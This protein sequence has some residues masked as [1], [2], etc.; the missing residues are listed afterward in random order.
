[1]IFHIK[2]EQVCKII[3]D[4]MLAYVQ[5]IVEFNLW[6]I[7]RIV[8]YDFIQHFDGTMLKKAPEIWR[9]TDS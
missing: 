7:I 8:W 1:M 2:Y 4:T 5:I 9:K 6:V 3:V